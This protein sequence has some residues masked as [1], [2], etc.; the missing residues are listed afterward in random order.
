MRYTLPSLRKK[1]FIWRKANR[2]FSDSPVLRSG[3]KTSEF[4]YAVAQTK[5]SHY[6]AYNST[7]NDTL[8]TLIS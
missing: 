4:I 8:H 5:S 3:T 7:S 6:H 1:I 2:W